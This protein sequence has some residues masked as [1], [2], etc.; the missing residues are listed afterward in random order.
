MLRMRKILAI[1]LSILLLLSFTACSNDGSSDP[2]S[3]SQVSSGAGIETAPAKSVTAAVSSASSA[4]ATSAETTIDL[5]TPTPKDQ[6]PQM[7]GYN[8]LWYDEFNGTGLDED[9]WNRE[10]RAAGWTNSELQAYTDSDQNVYVKDG[11]LVLKAVETEGSDGTPAYTSGKVTTKHKEDFLYGK[12]VVRAKVPEGQGLWPAIWMMP[13][14]EVTYG[15][16]PRCGEI[17]I[18]ELLGNQPQ[19]VYSTIH[20]GDPHAQQQGKKTLNEGSFADGFHEYSLEWEPGEM[21]FYVDGELIKT[22]NDWFTAF[23]GG[24]EKPYPAPF[25]KTFYLQ[26]NLAVGGTWPGNPDETTDFSKAEFQIDYVRVY[27]K[28]SYDTDVKKPEKVFRDPAEDGNLIYNGD[29]KAAEDLADNT[30][31]IFLTAD[32]GAGTAKIHDGM[33]TVKTQSEGNQEYSVQLVQPDLGL[34][35]GKTYR[36]TFDARAESNRSMVVCVSAPENGWARYLPDTKIDL[37]KDWTT[38]TYEFTMAEKDD[39]KGRLEFELGKQGTTAGVDIR[40]VRI[41]EAG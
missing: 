35:A 9:I 26:M 19:T 12:V 3:T 13:A 31:W 15:P 30:D 37:A 40:S 32:G 6:I 22:V 34:Y 2:A 33:L 4:A 38:Y 18:M 23:A 11:V 20:Y 24:K 14:D 5:V 27:Q 28:P 8:L 41:E 39:N 16:W 21:R 29:F 25:D 7:E 10:I 36:I 17:D 1:L